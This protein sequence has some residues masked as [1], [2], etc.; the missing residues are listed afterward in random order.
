MKTMKEIYLI[1]FTL[2]QKDK[3]SSELK[4]KWFS[5]EEI[6]DAINKTKYQ[7]H[8]CGNFHPHNVGSCSGIDTEAID[9]KDLIKRL[10]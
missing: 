2:L 6:N 3:N 7:R 8:I 1:A 10:G 9:V 4:K 5:E